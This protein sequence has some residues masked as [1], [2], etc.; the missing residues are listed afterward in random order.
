MRQL[1]LFYLLTNRYPDLG[2]DPHDPASYNVILQNPPVPLA[3]LSPRSPRGLRAGFAQSDAEA[4]A[5]LLEVG[6]G[7][8]RC[9]VAFFVFEFVRTAWSAQ[10]SSDRGTSNSCRAAS[11]DMLEPLWCSARVLG[12]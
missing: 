8:G 2:F 3:C 11:A 4:A 9:A 5:Q 1:T 12:R 7:N 6:P 10:G